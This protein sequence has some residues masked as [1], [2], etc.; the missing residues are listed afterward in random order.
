MLFDFL[1]FLLGK[2]PDDMIPPF[3]NV[4]SEGLDAA[5]NVLLLHPFDQ[6][7]VLLSGN[8]HSAQVI[9]I[10][11]GAKKNVFKVPLQ[12]VSLAEVFDTGPR[13]S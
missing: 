7:S 11:P 12:E 2:T 9:V 1:G 13:Y 5:H 10:Q 8:R 3:L 4:T 6:L